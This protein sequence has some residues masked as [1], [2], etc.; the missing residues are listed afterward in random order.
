MKSALK[1]F[2]V[3]LHMIIWSYEVTII[4]PIIWM[5]KQIP[6]EVN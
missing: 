1:A 4:M 5:N 3:I 2:S 6:T